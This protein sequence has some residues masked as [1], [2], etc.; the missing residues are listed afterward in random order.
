M[1]MVV[2]CGG[3]STLVGQILFSMLILKLVWG[4]AYA[5]G[6]IFGVVIVH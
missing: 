6:M 5:S 2:V 3:V 4:I 1:H